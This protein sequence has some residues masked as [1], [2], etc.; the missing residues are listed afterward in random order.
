MRLCQAKRIGVGHIELGLGLVDGAV[1]V[2]VPI[3]GEQVKGAV[4]VA[5]RAREPRQATGVRV[6]EVT[7]TSAI[8][9]TRVTAHAE[10][11]A[12]GIERRKRADRENPETLDPNDLEGSVPG[13]EG[14]VQLRYGV[15]ED[16]SDAVETEW[17]SVRAEDDYTHHFRLDGLEPATVYYFESQTSS[18]DGSSTLQL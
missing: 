13:A 18:A 4:P 17:M 6:G 10:R 15:N 3:E 16:L 14:R 12:D 9:W 5:G 1:G 8:V 7:P 11:R 2:V